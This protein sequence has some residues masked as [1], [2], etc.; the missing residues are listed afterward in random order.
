MF[1]V[2]VRRGTVVEGTSTGAVDDELTALTGI[3]EP[4]LADRV[5][6]GRSGP[7]CVRAAAPTQ[8]SPQRCASRWPVPSSQ[9]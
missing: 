9:C 4:G 6:G 2:A 8:P 7:A 3:V 5:A 1:D